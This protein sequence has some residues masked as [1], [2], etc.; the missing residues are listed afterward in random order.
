MAVPDDEVERPAY[1]PTP[2]EIAEAAAKIREGWSEAEHNKRAA[3][4]RTNWSVPE[5][6]APGFEEDSEA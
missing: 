4:K 3:K 2:E 5:V 6:K 1:L